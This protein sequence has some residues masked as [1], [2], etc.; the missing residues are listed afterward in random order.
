MMASRF[1][2]AVNLVNPEPISLYRIVELYKK[3]KN[4][5]LQKCRAVVIFA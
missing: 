4:V 2:G 5:D 1:E 3:V